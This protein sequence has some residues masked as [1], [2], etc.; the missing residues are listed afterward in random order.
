ML[1]LNPAAC[2]LP[3]SKYGTETRYLGSMATL[4][5]NLAPALSHGAAYH[6]RGTA[7]TDGGNL[8]QDR[9]TGQTQDISPGRG[10]V[11]RAMTPL[12]CESWQIEGR[13]RAR[14]VL[15]PMLKE[16]NATD[17]RTLRRD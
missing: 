9:P 11:R 1:D 15:V 14:R 12:V 17:G 13:G 16:L 5:T 3:F 6:E 8:R 4:K 2:L 7:S 10:I